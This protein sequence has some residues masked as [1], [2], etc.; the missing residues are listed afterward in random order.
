MNG[1]R[2]SPPLEGRCSTRPRK[3]LL[4]VFAA[5]SLTSGCTGPSDE[6]VLRRLSSVEQELAAL[7]QEISEDRAELAKRFDDLDRGFLR[8]TKQGLTVVPE[9]ANDSLRIGERVRLLNVGPRGFR[10]PKRPKI[11]VVEFGSYQCPV[12]I[13]QRSFLTDLLDLYPKNLGISFLN[14]PLTLSLI[15]I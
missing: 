2:A 12:C 8:L 6:E 15:H 11:K 9:L 4:L 14:Y 5:L 10:G 1:R 7:R 3:T 13:N